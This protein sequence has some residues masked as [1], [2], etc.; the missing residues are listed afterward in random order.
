MMVAQIQ[1][2][3]VNQMDEIEKEA[4]SQDFLTDDFANSVF[5]LFVLDIITKNHKLVILI[6]S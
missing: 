3:M 2:G 6:P 1:M 5:L 4:K